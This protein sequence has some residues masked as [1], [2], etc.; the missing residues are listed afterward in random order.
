MVYCYLVL[1]TLHSH[2]LLS[3]GDLWRMLSNHWGVCQLDSARLPLT[4]PALFAGVPLAAAILRINFSFRKRAFVF[5]STAMTKSKYKQLGIW[6]EFQLLCMRNK[7]SNTTPIVHWHL[8]NYHGAGKRPRRGGSVTQEDVAAILGICPHII[9]SPYMRLQKK[10][11]LLLVTQ[12]QAGPVQ[13]GRSEVAQVTEWFSCCSQSFSFA[14][15]I[16][17]ANSSLGA[18]CQ[19]TG[20]LLLFSKLYSYVPLSLVHD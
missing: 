1:M 7:A 19:L 13:K 11:G 5:C 3:Y 15:W 17:V 12:K 6:P 14:L 18:F 8:L 4:S 2:C 10:I 16:A 20:E 9:E